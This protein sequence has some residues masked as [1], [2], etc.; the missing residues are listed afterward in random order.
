MPKIS[1]TLGPSYLPRGELDR[2]MRMRESGQAGD[3]VEAGAPSAPDDT[4]QGDGQQPPDGT[5][6]ASGPP[7]VGEA[8]PETVQPPDGAQVQPQ[9]D[10]V[11]GT[12]SGQPTGIS[13]PERPSD[14]SD[15]PVWVNYA[16]RLGMVREAAQELTRSQLQDT[17]KAI[18]DGTLWVDDE[19]VLRR[20]DDG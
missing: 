19:G 15:K 17:T 11:H 9:A 16:V 20:Q 5:D 3:P 8:G 10:L 12:G 2:A 7:Q 4:G 6:A 18:E 14:R 1:R 13:V